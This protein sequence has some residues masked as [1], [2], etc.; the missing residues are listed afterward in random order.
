MNYFQIIVPTLNSFKVL[1]K[2]IKSLQDQTWQYWRVIF[3]DGES[4]LEHTKW[5]KKEC[6]KEERFTY[7]KQ[8]KENIGIFGAMN[9]GLE[10][11]DK[12]N[13]V[14]FW[15]SDDWVFDIN[16]F[17][18]L[19]KK[20]IESSLFNADMIVCK[21]KYF[22]VEKKIYLRNAFFKKFRM[23]K[24][25]YQKEYKSLIFNGF[26]PPHQATLMHPKLFSMQKPYD[27]SFKL[28]GDLDFFCRICNEKNISVGIINL[29]LVIISSGGISTKNHIRRIKEVLISY[30]KIFNRLFF[31]PFALRYLYKIIEI[32]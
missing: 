24:I 2:L 22:H 16:T 6:A 13:W 3:V 25:I 5:L 26:T 11:I 28:A 15:G 20:I 32:L 14:L 27:D 12:K 21:G 18:F 19:N 30:G 1:N 10:F 23:D 8:K 29:Y 4:N 7:V 17:E 9:Q 31:F